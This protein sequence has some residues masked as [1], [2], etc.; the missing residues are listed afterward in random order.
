MFVFGI[1]FGYE[2]LMKK[3][4]K[5]SENETSKTTGNVSSYASKLKKKMKLK[6][7]SFQKVEIEIC[8]QENRKICLKVPQVLVKN[9]KFEEI[10]KQFGLGTGEKPFQCDSCHKSFS[11]KM[12]LKRHMVSLHPKNQELTSQERFVETKSEDGQ[13][14]SFTCTK[15]GK[16]F[17]A[18]R[19]VKEHIKKVHEQV[20][21]FK[22]ESC[23]KA[24]PSKGNL[25]KHLLTIHSERKDFECDSCGKQYTSEQKLIRHISE[26]H[27]TPEKH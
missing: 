4:A 19:S 6:P 1:S 17:T 14:S 15:C 5:S 8:D 2:K 3:C 24:F 9:G 23:N 16:E 20:K 12:S 13:K 27:L 22:C 21:N 7:T 26:A 10:C 18:M 25:K 11:Q